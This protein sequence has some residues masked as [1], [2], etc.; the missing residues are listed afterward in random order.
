M[1][2]F[3]TGGSNSIG[4]F[5]VFILTVVVLEK[6]D[7]A[8]YQVERGAREWVFPICPTDQPIVR[9]IGLEQSRLWAYLNGNRYQSQYP[10]LLQPRNRK[11]LPSNPEP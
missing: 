7:V 1:A 5:P 10:I 8:L 4:T 3:V 6:S 2:L 9:L 11:S